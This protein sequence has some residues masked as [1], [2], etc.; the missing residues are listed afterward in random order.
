MSKGDRWGAT[1]GI[2]ISYGGTVGVMP[3]TV[4]TARDGVWYGGN[5]NGNGTAAQTYGD[6]Q[7]SRILFNNN[8]ELG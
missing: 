6:G 5:T 1:N 3:F 8:T 4:I 2:I 7:M